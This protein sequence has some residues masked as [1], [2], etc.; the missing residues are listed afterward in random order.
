[1]RFTR[2]A[3]RVAVLTVVIGSMSVA[4]AAGAPAHTTRV[5]VSTG[6]ALANAATDFSGIAISDGGRFVVFASGATN[7]VA[8]DTNG[9]RDVFVRNTRTGVTTRADLGHGGVQ[10]NG[11]SFGPV[12]IS[13]D[14]RFVAFESDASNLVAGSGC[15]PANGLLCLFVHDRKLGTNRVVRRLPDPSQV[16]LSEHGCYV[17]GTSEKGPLL[18]VDQHTGEVVRVSCC[19]LGTD[20]EDLSL[21]GMSANAN[22]IAFGVNAGPSGGNPGILQVEVRNVGRRTTSRISRAPGGAAGNNHSFAGGISPGGRYVIYASYASNLV[23]GDTNGREDVFVRDR[24]RG[25]THRVDVG[26]GGVQ[27]NGAGFAIGISAGG[28]YR[29]FASHASNL[30][31][32]DTNGAW[33]VFIRDRHTSRTVRVDLTATGGQ[34]NHGIGRGVPGAVAVTAGARWLAFVSPST[35]VHPPNANSL[36]HTYL[37]GP[38]S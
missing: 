5:D 35:N 7:L 23:A 3:A 38:L 18:R 21:G 16:A 25:T 19:G 29:V 13:G 6:G 20:Y 30:V 31:A 32:G 24:R 9:M 2:A 34:A 27:A 15:T 28:R 10:A 37:R 12:A 17:V 22:L 11:E 8:G 26:P 14:G 33:D 36:I 4:T 1:M